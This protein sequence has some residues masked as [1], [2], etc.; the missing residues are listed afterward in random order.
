MTDTSH[1]HYPC[2]ECGRTHGDPAAQQTNGKYLWYFGWKGGGWNTTWA[3]TP[4]EAAM[5]LDRETRD[6]N[7]YGHKLEMDPRT[8][9]T[10][11]W[12]EYRELCSGWD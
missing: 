1:I 3:Y 5:N 2:K 9:R 7:R 11:S 4:E 10:I 12:S 6:E 8:L